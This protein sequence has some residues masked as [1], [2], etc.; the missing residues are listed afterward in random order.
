MNIGNF[1]KFLKIKEIIEKYLNTTCNYFSHG[2]LT[3]IKR[4]QEAVSPVIGVILMVAITVVLA[5]ILY[6]WASSFVGTAKST[7]RAEATMTNYDNDYQ[8]TFTS[9]SKKVAVFDITVQIIDP[10]GQT[11]RQ[12]RLE[13]IYGLRNDR[14]AGQYVNPHWRITF[15]DNDYEMD[16]AGYLSAQDQIVIRGSQNV[17]DAPWG[18]NEQPVPIFGTSGYGFK[19][20]FEPTGASIIEKKI[21]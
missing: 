13:E 6:V 11:I 19:L 10:N 14:I 16:G 20:Q 12:Y 18:P 21:I 9:V 15:L 1:F 3:M 4:N 8:F 17:D 5:A 7:P 2:G